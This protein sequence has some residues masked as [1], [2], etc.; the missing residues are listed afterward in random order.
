MVHLTRIFTLLILGMGSVLG[1]PSAFGSSMAYHQYLAHQHTETLTL[2]KLYGHIPGHVPH[3]TNE[4][5][6]RFWEANQHSPILLNAGFQIQLCEAV[7]ARRNL[8]PSNFD[9]YHPLL[10]RLLSD[11]Q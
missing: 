7:V 6:I 4:G 3:F 9:H 5:A 11:P 1:G 10:G 8:N 2:P